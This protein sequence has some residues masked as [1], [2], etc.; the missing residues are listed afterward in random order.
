MIDN[1]HKFN[2]RVER[3]NFIDDLFC[4]ITDE[5]GFSNS[6]KYS[7]LNLNEFW[8][9][10]IDNKR[11]GLYYLD[12]EKVKLLG[13]IDNMDKLVSMLRSIEKRVKLYGYDISAKNNLEPEEAGYYW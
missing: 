13:F 2:S 10:A 8:E 5:F 7:I 3:E 1:Y 9:E 6:K 12:D 11:G 4:E